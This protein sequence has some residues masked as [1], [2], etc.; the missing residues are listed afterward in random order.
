MKITNVRVVP[1]SDPVPPGKRHRTDSG[2][3]I[4]SDSAIIFVDT[5]SGLCGTGAAMTPPFPTS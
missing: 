3:K 2:T 4:K 1:L 5:D